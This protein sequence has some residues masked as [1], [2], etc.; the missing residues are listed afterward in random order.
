MPKKNKDK[1]EF[2]LFFDE[3]DQSSKI[4][5]VLK[6][7]PT[8]ADVID[9]RP[10]DHTA[11]EQH[12]KDQYRRELRDS[13][14]LE[15]IA[16]AIESGVHPPP[17]LAKKA[18]GKQTNKSAWQETIQG[19]VNVVFFKY[20]LQIK[21]SLPS[22]RSFKGRVERHCKGAI[23]SLIEAAWT[24][25]PDRCRQG[26]ATSQT[27][28]EQ[29][30]NGLPGKTVEAIVS[31][32]FQVFVHAGGHKLTK[33]EFQSLVFEA[34]AKTTSKGSAGTINAAWRGIPKQYKYKGLPSN[35]AP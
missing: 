31:T 22:F 2:D 1:D 27:H 6:P 9:T 30:I 13:E 17:A 15:R 20:N 4:L 34:C 26:P 10:P 21:T 3:V 12:V 28:D 33:D 35:K 8:L 14:N 24:G 16:Q 32:L 18:A 19:I 5:D 25:I 23:P 11:I 29:W 7:L